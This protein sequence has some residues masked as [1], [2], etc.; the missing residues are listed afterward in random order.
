[1]T[2]KIGWIGCGIHATQMLLP[3]LVRHDVEIVALCDID[4]KRLGDAG[5]QFG[6]ARLTSDAEELIRMPGIDAIGM[7]VGPDHHLHFGKLALDRGLPVFMEKPPSGTAAGARELRAASER[8]GK[9]LL[10]GFMKRY[11][12]G[13]KIAH[14]IIKS[15]RFG[16]V[17]G[18]TGYY[19]TAPGYFTGNV[20]YTGFFLHHCVHYMDLVSFFVSPVRTIS[21]RKVEKTP[22]R[23]LFH[24]GFEFE[25]GAIGNI[26]MGTI[27]SRGTPVE[28]I[29]L[30]GDHQRIE[31][32]DVIEVRWN[33]N[34]PFKIDDPDATLA[35]D[36]DTL[37]WKPNF[38]AAANE[39][40][41]GYY[42]LLTDVVPALGGASTAAPT[43][44]DG[45]NAM[46]W[47]E[48]LRRE[49]VL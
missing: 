20:D 41:K 29:E 16:P 21:A 32:D 40:P 25:C 46:E 33:R 43:I 22:G 7:A 45:V 28:R 5:R 38:T 15:G 27:Q 12:V 49:L 11:S 31:V 30:M 37:T 24:V 47:L 1:M 42:S 17:L 44:H 35:D 23:V 34:P 19:M 18:L 10:V 48:I 3:Q 2:L 6:V 36:V 39:D 4:G 9:P 26:A 8:A 13:N 14:N